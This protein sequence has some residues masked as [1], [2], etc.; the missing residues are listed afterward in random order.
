MIQNGR[1]SRDEAVA[2]ARR[3]DGEFPE[4]HLPEVLDYIGV[5]RAEFDEVVDRH[6]NRELWLK[7][8]DVWT[9]RYPVA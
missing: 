8:D 5:S 1:M 7:E 4:Q 2:L 3:F 6:R 9:L